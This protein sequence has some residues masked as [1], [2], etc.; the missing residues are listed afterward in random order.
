MNFERGE[1]A[2]GT[3]SL[4]SGTWEW[5]MIELVSLPER[6]A[7]MRHYFFSRPEE[8]RNRMMSRQMLPEDSTRS[9]EDL[10]K[11]PTT[12]IVWDARS[13]TE[14]TISP[15]KGNSQTY[16]ANAFGKTPKVIMVD[17]PGSLGELGEIDLL[18]HLD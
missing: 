6:V 15:T 9:L 17:A 12:R 16:V 10:A 7:E 13:Q 11:M 3:I 1:S 4:R 18:E 2:S 5:R 8:P 14:W